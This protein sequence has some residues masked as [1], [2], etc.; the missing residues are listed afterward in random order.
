MNPTDLAQQ[1]YLE[2]RRAVLIASQEAVVD[3]AV[4]ARAY[5]E[6]LP[7]RRLCPKELARVERL[8]LEAERQSIQLGL[9]IA[10]IGAE[11]AVYQ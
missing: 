3:A 1:T 9:A 6:A 8:T 7:K 4:A 10:A 2:Y 5:F 11:L